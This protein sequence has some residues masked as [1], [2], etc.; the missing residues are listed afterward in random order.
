MPPKQRQIGWDCRSSTWGRVLY[1]EEQ[2]TAG[3]ECEECAIAEL[4]GGTMGEYRGKM[5]VSSIFL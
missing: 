3:H 1:Y 4:A 5:P 2:E